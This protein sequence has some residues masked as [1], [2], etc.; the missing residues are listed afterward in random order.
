MGD[1]KEEEVSLP[2]AKCKKLA[3]GVY[4]QPPLS[5]RGHGPAVVLL[6]PHASSPDA[7][8]VVGDNATVPISPRQKWAEE[9]FAVVEI[10][11]LAADSNGLYKKSIELALE[12]LYQC[13]SCE[14]KPFGLIGA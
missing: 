8:E 5:R 7:T 12:A 14:R 11:S 4:L 6:V 3:E 13:R 10:Q 9:G 1:V 2:S